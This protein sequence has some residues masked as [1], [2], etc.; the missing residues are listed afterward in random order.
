MSHTMRSQTT[1]HRWPVDWPVDCPAPLHCPA[2]WALEFTLSLRAPPA[3][4]LRT[5]TVPGRRLGLLL[6]VVPCPLLL[7]ACLLSSPAQLAASDEELRLE[8]PLPTLELCRRDQAKKAG[9]LVCS[10]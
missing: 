8:P 5:L 9:G 6:P 10:C 4:A 2:L 7:L 3:N 1:S